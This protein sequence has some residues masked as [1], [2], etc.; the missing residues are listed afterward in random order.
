MDPNW[1]NPLY[2]L[3]GAIYLAT[4]MIFACGLVM[5][6]IFLVKIVIH[7]IREL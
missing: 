3:V 2:W 5:L 6:G 4:A 7:A 1:T